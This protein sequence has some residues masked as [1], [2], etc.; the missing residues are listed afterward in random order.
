M[1]LAVANESSG[2]TVADA[3]FG[4]DFKSDLVHQVVTAYMAGGRAGTKAQKTRAEVRGG[5]KKPWRQKGTGRARAGTIR[6]PLWS[7]GG[8]HFAARPRDFSQKINRK[9]YRGALRSIFSE[10]VRQQRLVVVKG[11]ALTERK[12]RGLLA[13]LDELGAGQ[14]GLIVVNEMDD[15]LRYSVSNVVG[16]NAVEAASIDPVSLVGAD[17]VVITVDAV[18]YLEGW[19]A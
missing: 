10:L 4:A 1:E 2:V 8:V 18:K 15:N 7:G 13:R 14:R 12:T 16:L 6:S 3:L 17:N 11:L 5:G 19:L 9:M